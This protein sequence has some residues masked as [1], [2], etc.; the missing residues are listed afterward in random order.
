MHA[1]F[2]KIEDLN[3]RV[4]G[5]LLLI[6]LI[7]LLPFLVWYSRQSRKRNR[8]LLRD[9][10][11][12]R[13]LQIIWIR[14]PWFYPWFTNGPFAA[15]AGFDESIYRIEV[16][17]KAGRRKKGLGCLWLHAERRQRALG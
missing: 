5:L 3:V 2:G 7:G 16:L 8:L 10:A 9:W 17:D 6:F 1:A 14:H 11:E 4:C 15:E 12:Q 13:E